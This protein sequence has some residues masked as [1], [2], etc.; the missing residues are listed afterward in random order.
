MVRIAH[1][2]TEVSDSGWPLPVAIICFG[3]ALP[4]LRWHVVGSSFEQ[5]SLTV[6]Y[7]LF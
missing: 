2:P 5:P 6:T 4:D 1:D 7:L 3:A